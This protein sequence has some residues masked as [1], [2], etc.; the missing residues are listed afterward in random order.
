MKKINDIIEVLGIKSPLVIK[1]INSLINQNKNKKTRKLILNIDEEV[2]GQARPRVGQFRSIYDPDRRSKIELSNKMV[3]ILNAKYG[4]K[5]SN[6]KIKGKFKL[7]KRIWKDITIKIIHYRQM[8]KGMAQRDKVLCLSSIK[9]VDR[10]PDIDN[11]TKYI[12]DAM[13]ESIIV[14]DRFIWK[15]TVIK[16]WG[17]EDKCKIIIKYNEEKN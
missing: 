7:E 4:F 10:I 13:N 17:L 11:I 15:C 9:K 16:K 2:K 14:D 5:I 8:P 12:L 1:S 6:E 3:N